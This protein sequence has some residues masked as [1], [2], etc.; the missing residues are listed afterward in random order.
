MLTEA[1][2]RKVK[3]LRH[4]YK[5]T[6]GRGLYLLIAPN[7]GR[8]WRFNYRFSGKHKTLALGIHPDVPLA[9][10]RV[11]LHVTRAL[12]A[13]GID[14]GEAKRIYGKAVWAVLRR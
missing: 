7:G 11:R 9:K 13:D 5:L 2:V 6:D 1:K 4:A 12:L 10:A 8:Y 3:S 14:P